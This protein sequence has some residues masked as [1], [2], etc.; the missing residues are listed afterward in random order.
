[1]RDKLCDEYMTYVKMYEVAFMHSNCTWHD[2]RWND[3]P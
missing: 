3:T 1:M 2:I